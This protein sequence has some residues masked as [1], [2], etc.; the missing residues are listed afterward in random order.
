[1]ME[2]ERH[3]GAKLVWM[4]NPNEINEEE[5]K[6]FT[7]IFKDFCFRSLYIKEGVI[8]ALQEIR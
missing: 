1:M 8:V 3:K 7:E 4:Y 6:D 5:A 2:L